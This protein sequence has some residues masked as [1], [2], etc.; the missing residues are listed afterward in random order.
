[1]VDRAV[2]VTGESR[3]MESIVQAFHAFQI[4]RTNPELKKPEAIRILCVTEALAFYSLSWSLRVM[5]T[6]PSLNRE[7]GVDIVPRAQGAGYIVDREF[8]FVA[9]RRVP[10]IDGE[11]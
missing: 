2:S 7:S 8:V 10:V 4:F 5:L 9:E 6:A 1:M 3:A 11:S